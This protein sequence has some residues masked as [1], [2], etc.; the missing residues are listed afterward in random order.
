M[1]GKKRGGGGGARAP[2]A[3]PGSALEQHIATY[4]NSQIININ[5]ELCI[6]KHNNT[7]YVA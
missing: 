6:I 7:M 3:P 2:F 1:K 5:L 4:W